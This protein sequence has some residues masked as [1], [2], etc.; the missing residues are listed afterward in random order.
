MN[1]YSQTCK[2]ILPKVFVQC[3]S[4]LNRNE[5]TTAN[6]IP[7]IDEL[8]NGFT[9]LTVKLNIYF[10]R[11]FFILVQLCPIYIFNKAN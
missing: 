3:I 2:T 7:N 11:F 1:S 6:N 10:L 4:Q 8:R 9:N 5:I